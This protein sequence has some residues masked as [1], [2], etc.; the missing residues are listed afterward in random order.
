MALTDFFRI[1][2]PYGLRKNT[3]GE[4]FAFN[5][6]YVPLGWNSTAGA[7][8][9]FADHG[10]QDYPVYTKYKGLTE[11]EILKII[12]DHDRIQR[13]TEGEIESIFFY[14]DRT[15]PQSTPK[16]WNEYFEIIKSFSKF[17]TT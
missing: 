12:T 17:T 7:K 5:R 11:K 15:N 9:I 14:D 13:N 6:E 3:K 8:S 10:H 1:N 2:L 4:W 16:H